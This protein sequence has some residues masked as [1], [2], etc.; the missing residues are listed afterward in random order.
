MNKLFPVLRGKV[1][2]THVKRWNPALP[3]MQIGGFGEISRH[4]ERRDP[5]A[6]VQLAGDYL[7]AAG[8]NTAV[9]FGVEAARN[10]IAHQC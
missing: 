2:M 5:K 3:L 6:R 1:D 7:S 10:I 9:A 4:N 8:Q